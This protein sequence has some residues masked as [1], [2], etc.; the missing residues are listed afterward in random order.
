M[1]TTTFRIDGMHCAGCAETIKTLIE[2]EPGVKV[3]M[4]SF[5]DAEARVFHDPETT[6]PERL[7][8][9]IQM[10]GYRIVEQR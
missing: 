4:V 10:P 8:A 5:K 9:V 6:P 1:K 7:A 2:R 3:A